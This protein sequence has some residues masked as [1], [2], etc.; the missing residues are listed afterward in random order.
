MTGP[1]MTPQ[2]GRQTGDEVFDLGYRHYEGI[3]EGR[4]R[5]R[6]AIYVNGLPTTLGLGRGTMQ[7]CSPS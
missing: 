7:R 5:A 6:R 1:P 4:A 2:P 3:R